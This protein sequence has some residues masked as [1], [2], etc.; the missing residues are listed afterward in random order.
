MALSPKGHNLQTNLFD[1]DDLIV[2]LGGGLACPVTVR[3]VLWLA[4]GYGVL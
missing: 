2:S 4:S 3:G 1:H